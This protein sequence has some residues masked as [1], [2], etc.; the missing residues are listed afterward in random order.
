MCNC[1]KKPV[2]QRQVMVRRSTNTTTSQK[3]TTG[4]RIIKRIIR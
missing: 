3:R 2:V 4:R 1:A